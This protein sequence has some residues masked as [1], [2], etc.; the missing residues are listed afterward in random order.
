MTPVGPHYL[1]P[2]PLYVNDEVVAAWHKVL[3][4]LLVL[5]APMRL[6]NICSILCRVAHRMLEL[7]FSILINTVD[8]E[9]INRAWSQ[10]LAAAVSIQTSPQGPS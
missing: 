4:A 2:S 10:D 5:C 8:E 9:S 1:F 6:L 3:L 7:A